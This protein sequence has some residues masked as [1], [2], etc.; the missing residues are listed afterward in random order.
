MI[1]EGSPLT[2]L[3]LI[4]TGRKARGILFIMGHN[5]SEINKTIFT[6]LPPIMMM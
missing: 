5:R 4:I 2:N 3:A 1:D 6:E